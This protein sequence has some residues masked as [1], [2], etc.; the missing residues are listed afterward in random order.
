M[1]E[2]LQQHQPGFWIALGFSL[3]AVEV[4]ITGFGT[5]VLLFAGLG[6][7]MAGLLMMSGL[8]PTSWLIGVSSF[9]IATGLLSVLLWQPMK[10]FQNNSAPV[11]TQNSDLMG[12]EFVLQDNVTL[13]QPGTHK[14]SGISWRVEIDDESGLERIA[15][16]AKV[17]V[18][19]VNV[20]VFKVRPK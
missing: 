17:V 20:G 14:Y 4:L 13:M 2:Y 6:A 19:G 10:R 9:G 18:S 1:I 8:L 7:I 12:L 11:G 5:I 15:A 3:L 16:G